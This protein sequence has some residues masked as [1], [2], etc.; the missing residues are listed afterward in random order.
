[1]LSYADFRLQLKLTYQYLF[2]LWNSGIRG[3]LSE[4]NILS[5]VLGA[6]ALVDTPSVLK[7]LSC[8][9]SFFSILLSDPGL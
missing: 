2:L 9:F 4:V 7:P 5:S 6:C 8:A 3:N 1:M